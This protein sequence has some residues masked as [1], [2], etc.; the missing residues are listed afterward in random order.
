MA[1]LPP[2]LQNNNPLKAIHREWYTSNET[3]RDEIDISVRKE[4]IEEFLFQL[5]DQ[6][7][8]GSFCRDL[9]KPTRQTKCT[10]LAD[11]KARVTLLDRQMMASYLHSFAILDWNGQRHVAMEWMKHAL[12]AK[13]YIKGFWLYLF[14]GSTKFMICK[15]ALARVIGF[16]RIKW[17]SIWKCFKAGVPLPL[18]GL[19][20]SES[21]RSYRDKA[22]MDALADF[23][24]FVQSLASP[25]ATRLIRALSKTGE[26]TT[27]LRDDDEDLIELPTYF[28]KRG[29]YKQFLAK[30]GFTYTADAVGRVSI[31]KDESSTNATTILTTS[32]PSYRTF[33]RYWKTKYA[34]MVIPKPREDICGDCFVFAN[35]SKFRIQQQEVTAATTAED[36]D[37]VSIESMDCFSGEDGDEDGNFQSALAS[38]ELI[39][40]A[41]I[42]VRAAQQQREYVNEKIQQAQAEWNQP[43]E[44]RSWC[45][46]ADYSQ[47][48]YVPSFGGEQPGE[49]Y[50]YSPA[51]AYC[52]GIVDNSFQQSNMAAYVYLE[53]EGKKGGNK[54]RLLHVVARVWQEGI[55]SSLRF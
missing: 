42:H 16:N 36:G 43:A 37:N 24:T 48:M 55:A 33:M 51:N 29:L 31:T 52:F 50:Y 2:Q 47:N 17:Q 21:N 25:R 23:F 54:Q 13:R 44:E 10:C 53:D 5:L 9:D 30:N 32:P 6:Q 1:T 18:H 40:K 35:Q 49:T 3:K 8:M 14:P 46:T 28:S 11:L 34:K 38:E 4:W 15:N 41:A 39:L 27:E 7:Q 19:T 12:N 20:G 45:F 22:T 26:N